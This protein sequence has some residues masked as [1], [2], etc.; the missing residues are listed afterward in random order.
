MDE[1]NWQV[2]IWAYSR[3][4]NSGV[5]KILV[6][7]KSDLDEARKVSTEEGMELAK[8]YNIAFIETSAKKTYNVEQAFL[9]MAKEIRMTV[10]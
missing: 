2:R 8:N 3:F 9:T 1:R 6:G 7:N 5:N 4:A 10:K